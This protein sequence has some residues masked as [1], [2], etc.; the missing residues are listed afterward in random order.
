MFAMYQR[1]REN[2]YVATKQENKG[3]C[4]DRKRERA[5]IEIILE[6]RYPHSREEDITDAFMRGY[7]VGKE[8]EHRWWSK[9]CANCDGAIDEPQPSKILEA[10]AKGY[11]DGAD[12]VKPKDE[13]QTECESCKH[14]KLEWFSEVCD[15]CSKAHSK[16]EPKDEQSGKEE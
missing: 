3:R 1:Y 8:Q 4:A 16:Y 14:N 13:P 2:G 7:E 10:Y 11:K 15:G 9:L 5:M 12:A 6:K